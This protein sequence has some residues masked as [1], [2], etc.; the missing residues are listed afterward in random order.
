MEKAEKENI[1]NAWISTPEASSSSG[2]GPISYAAV[3]T[4]AKAKG[5]RE[6]ERVNIKEA[7]VSRKVVRKASQARAKARRMERR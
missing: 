5:E 4:H 3:A 2:Q 6:I 7:S 1:P